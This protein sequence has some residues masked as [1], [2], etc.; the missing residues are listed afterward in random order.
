MLQLGRKRL[1]TRGRGGGFHPQSAEASLQF[2]NPLHAQFILHLCGFSEKL[3]LC[4]TPMATC[5]MFHLGYSRQLYEVDSA[6][7]TVSLR[8]KICQSG[9]LR[10]FSFQA[11]FGNQP[12]KLAG[13]LWKASLEVLAEAV[14]ACPL[15]WPACTGTLHPNCILAKG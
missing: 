1:H 15:G 2:A 9:I 7:R 13:P 10:N 3:T 11:D 5:S 14:E 8:R 6:C 12:H 4:R